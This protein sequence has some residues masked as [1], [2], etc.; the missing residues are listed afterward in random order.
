MFFS[1]NTHLKA[2]ADPELAKLQSLISSIEKHVATISFSPDG[3]VIS[4]NAQFLN[5]MGYSLN[6]VAGQHHSLFCHADYVRSSQYQD[7]WRQLNDKKQQK[8][9]VSRKKKNG[10][11]I[12]L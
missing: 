1:K 8:G 10:D 2:Q 3:K 7:F 11:N 4:A 5:A 6:E 12:W 9:L